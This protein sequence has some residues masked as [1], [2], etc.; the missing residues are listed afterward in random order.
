MNSTIF[1]PSIP[2]AKVSS[3][4]YAERKKKELNERNYYY[5]YI[6]AISKNLKVFAIPALTMEQAKAV[7]VGPEAWGEFAA[8][9]CG[10]NIG[11]YT[12]RQQDA[13]VLSRATGGTWVPKIDM[14]R[15]N[16]KPGIYY[17]HYHSAKHGAHIWYEGPFILPRNLYKKKRGEK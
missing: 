6:D 7:V 1:N 2:H 4:L 15:G 10:L 5:A 13:F 3:E 14:A 16:I 11:V 8:F 9:P 12:P 17:M